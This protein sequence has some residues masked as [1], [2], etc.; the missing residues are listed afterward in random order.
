MEELPIKPVKE[1]TVII[2]F[3]GKPESEEKANE[4]EAECKAEL[5]GYNVLVIF[6]SNGTPAHITVI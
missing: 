2:Q 4:I 6:N 1:K 3:D 5:P